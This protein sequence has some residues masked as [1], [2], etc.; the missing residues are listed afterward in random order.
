MQD[1]PLVETHYDEDFT[2]LL[3]ELCETWYR[4][5]PVSQ[6]MQVTPVLFTRAC[7]QVTAPIAP[8]INPHQTMFAGSIYTL[9]TLA[10]WGMIWLQQ[11][12]SQVHGHIIL[13]DASVKYL[14]PV[15]TQPQ[16][17]VIWPNC[18]LTPLLRGKRVKIALAV[19]LYC[20]DIM[21]ATFTGQ[22]MSLPRKIS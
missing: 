14:K 18:D 6:F 15:S 7:L 8:N 16:V 3:N 20:D 5:I 13:A 11:Q 9:M 19:E 4:T 12:C 2:A 21:C 10:G 17:K 1:K 22:Y